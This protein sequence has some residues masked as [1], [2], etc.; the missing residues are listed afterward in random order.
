M[1]YCNC[2]SEFWKHTHQNPPRGP[3]VS[4][5]STC[6]TLTEWIDIY[7]TLLCYAIHNAAVV[8]VLRSGTFSAGPI[9]SYLLCWG[10]DFVHYAAGV[11]MFVCTVNNQLHLSLQNPLPLEIFINCPWAITRFTYFLNYWI[12]DNEIWHM[13]RLTSSFG[14]LL[15][16]RLALIVRNFSY[17]P[18]TCVI[19]VKLELI[20]KMLACCAA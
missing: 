16:F 13:C 11:A 7:C 17:F 1:W 2:I 10:F 3:T 8:F 18:L 5:S 4:H 19:W 12:Y 9:S 15:T 6:V 20:Y 14:E